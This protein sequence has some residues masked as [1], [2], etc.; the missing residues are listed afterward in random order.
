MAYVNSFSG[1]P[2]DKAGHLRRDAQALEALLA[3]AEAQ[4]ALFQNM[5][6]LLLLE[7]GASPVASAAWFAGA[8]RDVAAGKNGLTLFLGLDGEGRAHFAAEVPASRDLEETPLAGIGRFEDMRGAA[9][10]LPAGEASMLG[11]AKALFEWHAKHPHC[12]Q[13]GARTMAAE[14]GWKRLCTEC[15]SEHFPRLDPVVIMLP[16]FGDRCCLGRQARFPRGMFSALAGFVEPGESLEEACAR[17]IK[18]EVGLTA[19]DVRYHSTQPWPFPSSLMIG[20]IA[21][22]SDDVVALDEEE[23][24]EAVW[25]SKDEARAALSGGVEKDGRTIWTPP[26]IAIAHHLLKAWAG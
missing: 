10:R 17:E 24:V 1:F 2:L 23:I 3:G 25:L 19:I 20:L 14:G 26:P 7:S 5:Q 21:E 4:L 18:E 16:V 12:A 22:V 11:C 13:C 6:P 8:A 15:K 9:M